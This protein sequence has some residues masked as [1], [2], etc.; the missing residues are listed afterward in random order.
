MP[1]LK[2]NPQSIIILKAYLKGKI[3]QKC[4]LVLDTGASYLLIPW[5]I[6]QNL[7]L[8]PELAKE[9]IEITIASGRELV[10]LVNIKSLKVLG[11]EVKNVKAVVHD[12]PQKAYVD[13]LLG[14]SFLRNFNLS[15]NF[16]KGVLELE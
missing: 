5:E 16:Q 15:I 13:G 12:L 6:A 9:R 4:R 11:K 3:I 8:K 7:G 1:K 2:F 10:P 14:L